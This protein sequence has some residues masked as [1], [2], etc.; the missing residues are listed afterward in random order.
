MQE[1]GMSLEWHFCDITTQSM[2][3]ADTAG[4]PHKG[5]AVDARINFIRR[6]AFNFQRT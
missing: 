3:V 5:A 4:G 6:F 1:S 2:G